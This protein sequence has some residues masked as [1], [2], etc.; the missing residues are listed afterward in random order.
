MTGHTFAS[1]NRTAA[2]A[3]AAL[4]AL[5]LT[6]CGVPDEAEAHGPE[7]SDRGRAEQEHIRISEAWIPEP[8]NPEIGVLYL[9]AHNASEADDPLV[10]VSTSASEDADLCTTETT[11]SGASQMR[12]VDEIPLAAGGSTELV[13]GGHHIMINEIAAPLETGDTVSVSLE[14]ASGTLVEFDVPVEPMS[15][16]ADH[17]HSEH[18]GG[19]HH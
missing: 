13:D 19:G 17:D 15:G 9:R 18:E 12:V 1:G 2:A 5:G 10:D 11:A 4:L 3:P 8:A 16:G 7:P 14:F 6:A